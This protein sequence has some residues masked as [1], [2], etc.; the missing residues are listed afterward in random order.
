MQVAALTHYLITNLIRGHPRGT[1]SM[2]P[3]IEKPFEQ[4]MKYFTPELVVRFNSSDDLE[5]DQ[6]DAEWETAMRAYREHLEGLRARMPKQLECLA[7]FCLHDAEI[8]AWEYPVESFIPASVIE[9]FPLSPG[10][11][12]FSVKQG[13]E[14]ISLMYAL[15]YPVSGYGPLEDWPF[16]RESVHWLYDEI[17]VVP[18]QQ[19][20]FIH[21]VLLSDGAVVEIPF[22]SVILHCFALGVGIEE[23]VSRQIA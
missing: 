3:Q 4:V 7:D 23:T 5:A 9:L 18:D 15:A 6:A 10:L 16:S 13:R 2:K 8:L 19:G 17:D 14:I 11:A 21:R 20:V 12:I 1:H 22:F